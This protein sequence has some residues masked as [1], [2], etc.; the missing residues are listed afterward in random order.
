SYLRL[1]AAR[2]D[3]QQAIDRLV[4]RLDRDDLDDLDDRPSD[5]GGSEASLPSR[6][7]A[8][9]QADEPAP[10]GDEP[11]VDLTTGSDLEAEGAHRLA[12]A[13]L[14]AP[15]ASVAGPLRRMV[16]AAVGRASE[17]SSPDDPEPEAS[18]S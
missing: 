18:A 16:R 13:G 2:D 17:G 10:A 9:D 1:L 5:G 7:T 11:V 15:T 6:P 3:L 12:S 8:P 4:S 14:E